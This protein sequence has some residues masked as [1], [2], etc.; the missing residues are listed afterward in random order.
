MPFDAVHVKP[1]LHVGVQCC[2]RQFNLVETP[3]I[4][5]DDEFGDFEAAP[6]DPEPVTLVNDSNHATLSGNDISEVLNVAEE[7]ESTTG[8]EED[9][10]DFG[11]FS[12]GDAQGTCLVAC[13]RIIV[14]VL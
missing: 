1:A 5:S 7:P 12:G 2:S 13:Y 3:C 6:V 8:V 9:F 14:F 10:G 11:D 4:M